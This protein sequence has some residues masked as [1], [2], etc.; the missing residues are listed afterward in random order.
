MLRA[1]FP[2]GNGHNIKTGVTNVTEAFLD[3]A[4]RGDVGTVM[5]SYQGLMWNSTGSTGKGS[6]AQPASSGG[7]ILMS[8]H[9]AFYTAA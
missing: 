9:L 6:W 8:S 2:S 1:F 7:Y 3:A 5:A 4:T